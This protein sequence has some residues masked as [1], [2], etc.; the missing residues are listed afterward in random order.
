MLINEDL[1][2]AVKCRTSLK[3]DFDHLHEFPI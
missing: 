2:V 3:A 1:T